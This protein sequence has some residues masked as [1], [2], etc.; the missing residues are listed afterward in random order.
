[1]VVLASYARDDP[2]VYGQTLKRTGGSNETLYQVIRNTTAETLARITAT[3]ARALILDDIIT[4]NFDPLNCLSRA[5]FID[6]CHVP[7]PRAERFSDTV[8]K[9]AAHHSPTVFTFDINRIVCP[10][11]PLCDAMIDGINVWRNDNHYS[12][13]IL[14]HLREQIWRAMTG[15][16]AFGRR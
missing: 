2:A 1:V 12:T 9:A 11:A 4:T 13:R 7:T 3:G 8:Y 6:Q 16:G 15:S 10:A 5:R 14:V